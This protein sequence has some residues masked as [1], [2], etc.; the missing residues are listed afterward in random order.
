MADVL[1]PKQ[2]AYCM[3]RIQG[4]NTKP[5]VVLRKALWASGLRYR[6]KNS[7]PGR[8]DIIF[9]RKRIAVF[10]DGCFWH[11]CPKHYQAPKTRAKFW[12]EKIAGNVARDI[13]NNK[14]LDE[15]S[16]MVVRVWEHEIKNDLESVV[17]RIIALHDSVE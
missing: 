13:R 1:S 8:P 6:I 4:K 11:R 3:S 16:W 17:N 9:P 7:L 12:E 10:V 2:R 15:R 14:N 5:E